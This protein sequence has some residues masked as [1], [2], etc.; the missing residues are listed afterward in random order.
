M[1]FDDN[2]ANISAFT[3]WCQRYIALT[4]LSMVTACGGGGGGST[5]AA[6]A[7]TLSLTNASSNLAPFYPGNPIFLLPTYT[8]G[9]GKITWLDNAGATQT[10]YID[11]S[12]TLVQINPLVTTVYTLTVTYQDPTQVRTNLLTKTE[13][14]TV[15]VTP[16]ATPPV[17]LDLGGEMTVAR[18]DHASV[19][20]PDGRVLVIGG[21]DSVNVL[22]SSEL[23]DPSTETW[24]ASGDMKT[25]R[26]GHSATLLTD[27][28]V[29]VTGGFDGKAALATA[30]I[31]DPSTGVWTAALG[32]MTSSRRFHSATLLSDGKVLIAGGVVGP[33]VTADPKATE[34]YNPATGLFTAYATFTETAA[35]SGIGTGLALPEARQ[36]HTATK[37]S[38]GNIL[39]V[40]NSGV[41]SA[42]AKLLAYDSAT[43]T[44]SAWTLAGTMA[45]TRYN[46]AAVV[47]TDNK[48]FVTGGFG[49][50][51]GTSK[52]AEIYDP[53]SNAWSS[54]ASMA[55]DRALHTSTKLQDGRVLVVGGYDGLKALTTVEIY[56]PTANTWT[57]P[58]ASKVLN[59]ARAM[60]TSSLLSSGDVLIVGTYFQTSGTIS[61]TTEIWRH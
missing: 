8:S 30:E 46:H 53:T 48:V 2:N 29:L 16:V 10:R 54:A 49:T 51:T 47:L 18:S 15:T 32:P 19:L 35:G 61:K 39:F 3:K 28:K 36:G 55:T 41:N 42:A 45:N 57:A 20:L 6:E 26:R 1:N 11:K 56:S 31:Y 12:G 59:T 21:T 22:K 37:L 23:F 60:H 4:L 7:P 50:Q 44:A 27:G 34:L 24:R 9:A 52:S 14:L 17:A 33:L 58:S 40:G 38:T 43:P 5:T 25:A 13:S